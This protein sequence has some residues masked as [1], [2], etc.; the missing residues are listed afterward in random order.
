MIDHRDRDPLNNRIENLRAATRSQNRAN[1]RPNNKLG[2]K[3]VHARGSRFYVM[4][5]KLYLGTFDSIEE[6]AAA[7]K[8]KAEELHGAFARTGRH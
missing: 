8:A 6:A 2:V 1:S 7:Y 4:A 5:G 3:G